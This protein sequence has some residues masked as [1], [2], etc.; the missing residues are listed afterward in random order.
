VCSVSGLQGYLLRI[1]F[2]RA[3]KRQQILF[4]FASRVSRNWFLQGLVLRISL[5][6]S[7]LCADLDAFMAQPHCNHDD[8]HSTLRQMT[9]LHPWRIKRNGSKQCT[10]HA[11]FHADCQTERRGVS[12]KCRVKSPEGRIQ[13]RSALRAPPFIELSISEKMQSSAFFRLV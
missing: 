7:R 8:V 3:D 10:Q 1:L 6:Q 2:E 4:C 11:L 12:G 13:S 9:R 5:N